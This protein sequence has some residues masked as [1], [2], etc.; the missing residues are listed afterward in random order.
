MPTRIVFG[1]GDTLLVHEEAA[2]VVKG[3]EDISPNAADLLRLTRAAGHA[4]PGTFEGT[5][6]YVRPSHVLYVTPV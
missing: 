3:L 6:V 5:A 1:G 2:V 4:D